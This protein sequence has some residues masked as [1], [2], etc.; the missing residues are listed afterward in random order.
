MAFLT[1]EDRSG[2]IEA[3]VFP[4][5]LTS[6]GSFLAEGKIVHVFG[7]L[8]VREDEDTKIVCD[9]IE[10]FVPGAGSD[11]PKTEKSRKRR[12]L[13]L[14]LPKENCPQREKAEKFLRI[15]EGNTR[16]YYYYPDEGRYDPRP[17]EESVDVNEPLLSE[18]RRILGAENVVYIE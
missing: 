9:R 18:L 1:L 15:F 16:L 7:K 13:F 10:P 12:G 11:A 8:S 2:S 14:R 6:A 3:L 5:L 17:N 4:Q